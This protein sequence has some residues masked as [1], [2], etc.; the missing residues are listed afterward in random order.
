MISRISNV[1]FT[2]VVSGDI[3]PA[4]ISSL[5][6][7]EAPIVAQLLV[8]S[9]IAPLLPKEYASLILYSAPSTGAILKD[10]DAIK[11]GDMVETKL[12]RGKFRSIVKEIDGG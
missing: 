7:P 1:P 10:P 4:A 11:I 5:I 12:G 6:L 2:E 3:R 8:Y 9:T